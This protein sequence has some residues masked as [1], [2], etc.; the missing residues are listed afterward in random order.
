MIR[1]RHQEFA[2]LFFAS[3]M[4]CYDEFLD[5]RANYRLWSGDSMQWVTWLPITV[6]VMAVPVIIPGK[7]GNGSTSGNVL[8][9]HPG[10]LSPDVRRERVSV[11]R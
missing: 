11:P 8:K 4:R 6:A 3:M 5:G 1:L 9:K 10:D 2:E 7:N